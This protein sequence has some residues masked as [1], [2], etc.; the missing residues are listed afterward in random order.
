MPGLDTRF[1]FEFLI[2]KKLDRLILFVPWDPETLDELVAGGL[3]I[4]NGDRLARDRVS[5]TVG[6]SVLGLIEGYC[7]TGFFWFWIDFSVFRW[8]EIEGIGF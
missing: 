3:M 1:L 7:T 4:A 8:K 6:A 2:F 5:T